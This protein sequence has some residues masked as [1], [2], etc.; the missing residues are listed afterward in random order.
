MGNDDQHGTV[1]RSLARAIQYLTPLLDPSGLGH[2]LAFNVIKEWGMHGV[3]DCWG[4][5]PTKSR[6]FAKISSAEWE[7]LEAYFE[8]S[9]LPNQV[10]TKTS[11]VYRGLDVAYLDV[12]VD[13]RQFEHLVE[14][15]APVPVPAPGK[16]L[17]VASSGSP[18]AEPLG[19]AA[20]D[21][22][23]RAVEKMAPGPAS[24]APLPA[25]PAGAAELLPKSRSEDTA[26]TETTRWQREPVIATMKKLYPPDGVRPKGI[27][28]AVLTTRINR[29]PEFQGK[30]VSEDT[31]RLADIEIKAALKKI[32]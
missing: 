29:E 25:P 17:P 13:W 19:S 11:D 21:D 18:G 30:K 20:P 12:V 16:P 23:E 28:I 14:E 6:E 2:A 32:P 22:A 7:H 5:K 3:L 4:N 31:V 10:F 26:E 8:I 15:M 24:A 27:S 1:Q 9:A